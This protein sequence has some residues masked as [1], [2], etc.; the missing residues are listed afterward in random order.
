M[1]NVNDGDVVRYKD[2]N[3]GNI[4]IGV[5]RCSH[6]S[7]FGERLVTLQNGVT[8]ELVDILESPADSP[9]RLPAQD[10]APEIGDQVA[11]VPHDGGRILHGKVAG[12]HL[13]RSGEALVRIGRPDAPLCR[14]ATGGAK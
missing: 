4:H 14:L 1:T 10:S 9:M 13:L 8:G 12:V 6:A 5:A 2:C 3:S 7:H 11:Y